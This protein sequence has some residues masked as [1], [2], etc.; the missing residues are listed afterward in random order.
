M[1]AFMLITFV[2][3]PFYPNISKEEPRPTPPFLS[4]VIFWNVPNTDIDLH[5]YEKIPGKAERHYYYSRNNRTG[6]E[7]PDSNASLSQ[8]VTRGPGVEIWETPEFV[9]GAQYR[10]ALVYY[11]RPDGKNPIVDV[12]GRIYH[13]EGYHRLKPR[14]LRYVDGRPELSIVDARV[15][16]G[17][18]TVKALDRPGSPDAVDL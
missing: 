15:V 10:F 7:Y 18:L 2:I 1:G 6:A 12:E 17:R 14:S 9:D 5:I 13:G 11:S 8:D 3:L 4:F 16:N